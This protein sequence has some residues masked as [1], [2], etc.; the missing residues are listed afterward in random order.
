MKAKKEN[1]T[2]RISNDLEKNRYLKEGYDIYDDE[3]KLL[4]YSPLKKIAY[5]A[6]AKV[7]AEN[8]ELRA[9]N[10]MLMTKIAELEAGKPEETSAKKTVSKKTGE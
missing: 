8:A 7:E 9:K 3:G 10:A 6:Y 2:Y 5:S 1:K 4:E